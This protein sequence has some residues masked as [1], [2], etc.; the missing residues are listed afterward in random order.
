M[1]S[2][3]RSMHMPA[4]PFPSW[5]FI[6]FDH[7]LDPPF[8]PESHL[9]FWARNA[10]YYGLQ[11]LGFHQGVHVLLP[12][13]LCTAAVEPFVE[14]G[15]DV[16][17]YEVGRDC[18][19]NFSDLELKINSRTE[20]IL[21]VHYFGFPQDMA[22]FREF[23]DAHDIALIEDCAHVLNGRSNASPLGSFG[24]ISVFSWRKVLP[25]YDGAELRWNRNCR[26]ADVAWRRERLLFT[27]KVAKSLADRTL[28]YSSSVFGK[29]ISATIETIKTIWKTARRGDSHS[30]VLALDSNAVAF[31]SSLLNQPISRV[32]RWLLLHSDVES[33][34]KKRRSNYLFLQGEL[35][36][37]EGVRL[38]YAELPFSVCP[39]IFPVTFEGKPNAHLALRKKGIPAVTWGGV[40]PRALAMGQFAESEFLY[41]NLVFLPVHQNL[42]RGS[43]ERIAAAVRAVARE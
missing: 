34:I 17:F 24:D 29:G 13:F 35:R 3:F 22:R 26:S 2:H 30:P 23:C 10:L 33:I 42:T 19:P 39:W 32:S 38:L 15:A 5:H 7:S 36:G 8:Q 14:F 18:R 20:A 31:D 27:L 37:M 41:E 16:E 21:A 11:G 4:E 12:S 25:L 28:E 6:D 1:T 9:F 43:L 40:R